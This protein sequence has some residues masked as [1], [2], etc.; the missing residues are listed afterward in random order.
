MLSYGGSMS[1]STCFLHCPNLSFPVGHLED[2]SKNLLES[3]IPFKMWG[4][5]SVIL[6]PTELSII[7]LPICLWARDVN[8]WFWGWS[9]YH[10][11]CF[12]LDATARVL[13]RFYRSRGSSPSTEESQ[14]ESAPVQGSQG[15]LEFC[16]GMTDNENGNWLPQDTSLSRRDSSQVGQSN[17]LQ[18]LYLFPWYCG[19]HL[20]T[21]PL[22]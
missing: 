18:H 11:C 3:T 22:W 19:W 5:C 4:G 15:L 20:P 7:P 16:L 10:H 9:F 13:A 6:I 17:S 1:Q 2:Q 14:P 8:A 21:V 12:R